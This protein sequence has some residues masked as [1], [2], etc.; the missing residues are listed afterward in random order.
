[1]R[2][3]RGVEAMLVTETEEGERVE[4]T[5]ATRAGQRRPWRAA[6]GETP[7]RA[8]PWLDSR[9]QCVSYTEEKVAKMVAR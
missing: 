9:H 4:G 5:L 7:D 1:M 3:H 8:S 6:E 2:E